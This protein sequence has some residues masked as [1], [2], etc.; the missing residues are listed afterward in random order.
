MTFLTEAARLRDAS[1]P[2]PW[3]PPSSCGAAR[4]GSRERVDLYYEDGSMATFE[5]GDARCRTHCWA[6][7]AM[8]S[9]PRARCRRLGMRDDELKQAIRERAVLEGELRAPLRAALVVLPR[10]VPLRDRPAAARAARRPASRS[11]VARVEPDSRRLA[12]PELGAVPLAAAASLSSGLPFVIVRRRPR[13]TGRRIASRARSRRASGSACWRTSSRPAA[14]R[15]TPSRPCARQVSSARMR[16]AS[17]IARQAAPTLS[18]G[19]QC[20]LW[21]LFRLP[22]FRRRL[23]NPRKTRM[24]ERIRPGCYAAR[25]L[26]RPR[27]EE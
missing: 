26:K 9:P 10:Q 17:S 3:A 11:T 1:R 4:P 27:G 24:V 18:R 13:N 14:P 7:P 5:D 20:G 19:S 21:P 25:N 22:R 6:T 16:S 23:E 8:R 15:W 12:A 2:W